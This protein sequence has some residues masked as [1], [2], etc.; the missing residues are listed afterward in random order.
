[1][2]F[3]QKKRETAEKNQKHA[4]NFK[5]KFESARKPEKKEEYGVKRDFYQSKVDLAKSQIK[6]REMKEKKSK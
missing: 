5:G 2:D 1:M 6:L 4:D 3:F